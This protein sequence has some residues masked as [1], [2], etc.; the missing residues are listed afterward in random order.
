MSQFSSLRARWEAVD[1]IVAIYTLWVGAII[2]WRASYI[3]GW[4]RL[5]LIH[6]GILAF[7]LVLPA[8]GSAWETRHL[9][10]RAL[11]E[12]RDIL[13]FLRYAYPLPM[14]LIFFEEVRLTVNAI[15]PQAPYWFE[16]HLYAA[17]IA[18]FGDL[19]ARLLIPGVNPVTTEVV[20]FFY[21]SYYFIL[22]GGIIY[23]YRGTWG[24]VK[25]R[26]TLPARGYGVF[27][28]GMT[29]AFLLSFAHFP[30]LAAR[31]PW[32]N[33]ALMAEM[34]PFNGMV[35]TY[36]IEVVIEHGAVSGGCFPSAHVAGAWGIVFALAWTR[37]H[38]RTAMLMGFLAIGMTF[39]C[40]FTR[41]HHAMDMP[42][43]FL[44]GIAGALLGQWLTGQRSSDHPTAA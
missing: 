36:L 33:A 13:K 38:R 37:K 3:P 21:F 23:A 40:V 29:A 26:D 30:W 1:W 18:V 4:P 42:A 24:L 2:L 5:I 28:T 19:P 9:P 32:E 41:Y 16:P 15:F 7:L 10:I 6:L 11:T 12:A 25:D 44:C 31:G 34:P 43:G 20:H 22:I 14:Q 8:R 17:D 39:A 35:F 27:V